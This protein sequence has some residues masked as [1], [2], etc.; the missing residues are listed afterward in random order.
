MVSETISDIS[1]KIDL[2][3]LNATIE[4]AR[5]G[6]AGKG[7]AVV[8]SEIKALAQQT[9]AATGDIA[10]KLTGIQE[11]TKQTISLNDEIYE[12]TNQVNASSLDINNSVEQQSEAIREISSNISQVSLGLKEINQKLTETNQA[13]AQVAQEITE[14]NENADMIYSS[15]S[16][17]KHQAS[18]LNN[19]ADRLKE[20]VNKFQI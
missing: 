6:E 11:L 15:S 12:V 8:A 18:E 14:V 20:M 10:N 1:D 17:A 5:A 9:A 4:A 7:F 19:L 3:A 2:L 16:S 13:T